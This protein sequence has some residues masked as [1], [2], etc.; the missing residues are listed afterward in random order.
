MKIQL[1]ELIMRLKPDINVRIE[2]DS[3]IL[4]EGQASNLDG[5]LLSYSNN[6]VANLHLN[7]LNTLIITIE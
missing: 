1:H 6:N 4:I 7:M 5:H 3:V 2:K